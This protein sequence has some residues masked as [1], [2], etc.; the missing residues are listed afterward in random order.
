VATGLLRVDVTGYGALMLNESSRPVLRGEQPVRFRQ[1]VELEKKK[2]PKVRSKVPADLPEDRHA[3]LEALRTLRRKL[4]EE[5]GVPSFVIF[6]DSTLMQLV[7]QQ[8]QSREQLAQ[9]GGIGA[10]KLERYG[11]ALLDVLRSHAA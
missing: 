11:A 6:H 10:Q 7:M 5:Q 8:P 1:E 9:I 3:L 4:A 2:V